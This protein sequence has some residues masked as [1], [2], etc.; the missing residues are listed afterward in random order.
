MVVLLLVGAAL[1]EVFLRDDPA[2]TWISVEVLAEQAEERG[3]RTYVPFTV[4][5]DG[6]EAG[7]DVTVIFEVSMGETMVEETTVDIALL[8]SHGTHQGE[9]V[10]TQDLGTHTLTARVGAVQAP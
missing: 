9:L 8:A 6:A 5:N 2:G 3:G 7:K 1:V 10:T 4:R